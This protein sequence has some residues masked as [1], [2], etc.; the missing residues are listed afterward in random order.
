MEPRERSAAYGH[1]LTI[2]EIIAKAIGHVPQEMTYD[3]VLDAYEE[4]ADCEYHNAQMEGADRVQLQRLAQKLDRIRKDQDFAAWCHNQLH[5]IF[6]DC[7]AGRNHPTLVPSGRNYQGEPQFTKK[8]AMHWLK[9][10]APY[11]EQLPLDEEESAQPSDA[12][13]EKRLTTADKNLLITLYILAHMLGHLADRLI[14]K[15]HIPVLHEGDCVDEDDVVIAENLARFIA[16]RYDSTIST[17]EEE[18]N[19]AGEGLPSDIG[20][21]IALATVA[22]CYARLADLARTNS[23]KKFHKGPEELDGRPFIRGEYYNSNRIADELLRSAELKDGLPGQSKRA[24]QERLSKA[25]KLMADHPPSGELPAQLL[26]TYLREA[27]ETYTG[28]RP[29]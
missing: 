13:S 8:S 16:S 9:E 26:L 14:D 15:N 23:W 27:I 25:Q 21:T 7:A 22:Q 4:K 1:A 12:P 11:R 19:T 28:K 3:E 29:A 17:V 20:H 18:E 10:I 24:I 5:T 2:D 6:D